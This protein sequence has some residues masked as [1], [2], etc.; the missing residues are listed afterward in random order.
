[1]TESDKPPHT[2]PTKPTVY[3]GEDRKEVLYKSINNSS[4]PHI[5]RYATYF[6]GQLKGG[7]EIGCLTALL[8]DPD[9]GV[10]KQAAI[11]LA[12]SGQEGFAVLSGLI[13][14][15]DWKVRYRVCEALGLM[16]N[17]DALPL[18]AAALDDEKD[19][20]RYMAAKSLGMLGEKDA[21]RSLIPRLNDENVFVRKIVSVSLGKLGGK[22]SAVALR[23]RLDTEQ[24][25]DVKNVILESIALIG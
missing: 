16:A 8:R 14:D 5:R 22:E 2:E 18:L 20:V 15:P 11:A 19:H 17:R 13:D 12:S 24:S 7:R 1:M 25:E 3:S 10:R 6:L 23:K 9:K 4:D 21:E